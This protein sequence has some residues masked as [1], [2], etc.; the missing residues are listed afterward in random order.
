MKIKTLQFGEIEYENENV[1]FF[2]QGLPGFENFKNFLLL[3][4]DD[5]LFT[6]LNSTDD[7]E[8]SFPLFQLRI[9]D[10]SFPSDESEEPFG[11]V[12]L[13]KDPLKITVNMRAPVYIEQEKRKGCQRILDDENLP[14]NYNIFI[15]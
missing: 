6:F 3:K 15:Q 4:N 13:N 14:V 11:I 5:D 9:I 8:L 2:P 7:P 1:I 10:E 12:N